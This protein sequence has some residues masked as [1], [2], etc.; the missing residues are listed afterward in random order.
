MKKLFL[1]IFILLSLLGLCSCSASKKP[2]PQQ[3]KTIIV[4]EVSRVSFDTVDLK[5]APKAVRDIAKLQENQDSASWVQS[6]GK[7]YFIVSGGE[8][9]RNYDISVDEIL[10]RLPEQNFTWI[11]VKLKYTRKNQPRNTGEPYYCLVMADVPA[12]PAGVGFSFSGLDP[13][14]SGGAPTV[15]TPSPSPTQEVHPEAAAL[16]QP[17]PNQEISSPVKIKGTVKAAG[18]KRIRLSTRGGQI[19]KEEGLNTAGDGSFNTSLSYSPPEMA[20]PGELSVIV[21]NENNEKVLIRVPVV[22]K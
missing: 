15:K 10:Q 14:T 12:A 8:K 6:G 18:Q 16:D 20:T 4:P 17:A 2:A 1:S 5:S 22:I 3:N 7:A 19:I 13:G 21:V 9:A 11:D